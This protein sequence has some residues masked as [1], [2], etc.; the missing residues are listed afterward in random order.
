MIM[1]AARG[2]NG[3]GVKLRFVN[4]LICNSKGRFAHTPMLLAILLYTILFSFYKKISVCFKC[5]SLQQYCQLYCPSKSLCKP[6][7]N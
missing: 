6:G 5:T 4:K 7:L 1:A 3:G 2:G